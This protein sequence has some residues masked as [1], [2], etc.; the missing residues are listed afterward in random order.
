MSTFGMVMQPVRVM[1]V[2]HIVKD[3]NFLMTGLEVRIFSPCPPCILRVLRGS[4]YHGEHG[5][6]HGGHGGL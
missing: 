5:D 1:R 4:F 6:S 3:I 2:V